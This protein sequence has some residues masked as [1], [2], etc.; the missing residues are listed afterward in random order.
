MQVPCTSSRSSS[1]AHLLDIAFIP[2]ALALT[3]TLIAL[4]VWAWRE[5]ASARRVEA[6]ARGLARNLGISE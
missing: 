5:A 6:I 4:M 2:L 3:A 1:T